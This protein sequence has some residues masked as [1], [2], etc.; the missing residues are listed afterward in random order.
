MTPFSL[1][2]AG[3]LVEYTR[4]AVMGIINVTGD[5]FHAASR[6]QTS[7]EIAA[8][9]EQM[10]TEGVD[11]IDV[12]ACSTRPGS[13]PPSESEE[14][15]RLQL[16]LPVIRE[17]AEETPLSV[18]TYRPP[19]ARRCIE[20]LGANIINDVSMAA[21]PGMIPTVAAL[22]VPYVLMH[23]R[24]T[25]RT[26]PSLTDYGPDPTGVAAGVIAELSHVFDALRLAGVCDI[27]IDP[28]FGFAKTPAQCWQLMRDLPALERAF[29]CPLL[30]GLSR[31]SMLTKPSGITPADALEATVAAN[32][33]ALMQG[34]AVLRVHDVAP[35]RHAVDVYQQYSVTL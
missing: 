2:I 4:P 27:L 29:G 17:V 15:E 5:S 16:A 12:G 7:R 35:A 13:T 1:N 25:A 30:I 11:I 20:E 9:V 24:G 32:T 6:V 18:D 34:A 23:T 21:D 31:K 10:L 33:I 26:M 28:G 8:R 14:L 3:R 22:R 19:I